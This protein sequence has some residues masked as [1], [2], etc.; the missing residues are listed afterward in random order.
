[1]EY[2]GFF[3]FPISRPGFLPGC[4]D[5]FPLLRLLSVISPQ[6]HG[7]ETIFKPVV[8]FFVS[9]PG[10]QAIFKPVIRR[11]EHFSGCGGVLW[12]DSWNEVRFGGF[13]RRDED[14]PEKSMSKMR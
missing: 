9:F 14:S 10:C 4:T 3:F 5:E 12:S 1:M 8:R 6:L 7:W 2:L 13:E 11:S